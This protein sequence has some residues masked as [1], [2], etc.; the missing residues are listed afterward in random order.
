MSGGLIL[1]VNKDS[2]SIDTC[3][4]KLHIVIICHYNNSSYVVVAKDTHLWH[5]LYTLLGSIL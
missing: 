5:M 1:W 3:D 2:T 4:I